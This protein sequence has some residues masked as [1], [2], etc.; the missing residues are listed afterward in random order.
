MTT[1]PSRPPADSAPA[2]AG[3]RPLGRSLDP[4]AGESLDGY[5]LRLSCRLRVSPV[6]LA[7][8]PAASAAPAQ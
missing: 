8:S 2:P 4:I 3:L 7:S 6:R 1:A 5:L